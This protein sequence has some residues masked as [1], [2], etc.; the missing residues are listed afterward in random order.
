MTAEHLLAKLNGVGVVLTAAGDDL[1]VTAPK[2]VITEDLREKLFSCKQDLLS[3][4]VASAPATGG[5]AVE[6][7]SNRASDSPV[8]VLSIEEVNSRVLDAGVDLWLGAA[9]QTTTLPGSASSPVRR[10]RARRAGQM[11]HRPIAPSIVR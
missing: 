10:R 1:V 5:T 4:V 7:E 3:L 8:W 6:P 9:H 11:A 2:G